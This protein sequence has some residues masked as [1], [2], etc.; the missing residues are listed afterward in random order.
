MSVTECSCSLWLC[1]CIYICPGMQPHVCTCKYVCCLLYLSYHRCRYLALHTDG[2]S[3]R[4]RR[5]LHVL[6][7]SRIQQESTTQAKQQQRRDEDR[8]AVGEVDGTK[9][10]PRLLTVISNRSRFYAVEGIRKAVGLCMR[11]LA[12]DKHRRGKHC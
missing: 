2:R 9:R 7:I 4:A 3:T 11:S 6:D 1:V 12:T 8:S 10:G 5:T